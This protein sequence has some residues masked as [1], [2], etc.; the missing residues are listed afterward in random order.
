[1]WTGEQRTGEQRTGEQPWEYGLGGGQEQTRTAKTGS[2]LL[3][4][5]GD[6]MLPTRRVRD[7]GVSQQL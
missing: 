4:L 7:I 2:G 6:S 1:M 5:R 3:R